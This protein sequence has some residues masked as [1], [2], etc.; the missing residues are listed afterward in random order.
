MKYQPTITMNTDDLED[1]HSG[2]V[3]LQRGQWVQLAWLA[4]PS[5]FVKAS[6]QHIT[7]CHPNGYWGDGHVSMQQFIN[8]CEGAR[9]TEQYRASLQV[10]PV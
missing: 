6:P 3:K 9:K 10:V 5:R 1:L 7:L 2:T 8:C 4:K